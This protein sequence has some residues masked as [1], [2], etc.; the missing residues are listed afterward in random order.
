VIDTTFLRDVRYGLRLVA[1]APLPAGIAILTLGLGIGAA[2]AAFSVIDGVLLRP[3]PYPEPDRIVRLYQV[4]DSGARMNVSE[5]NFDD[6]TA[7]TRSFRAM[8]QVAPASAPVSLGDERVMLGGAVV[9][10][11]FFEVMGVQPV[12]GR[13][14]VEEEQRPGGRAAVVVSH[15]VWQDRLGA[16][17]L[18]DLSLRIGDEVHD[19]VG[20]MP[21]SF[22]YPSNWDYLTPR[23]RL[24]PQRSR[25][26]HNFQ[27]VARLADGVPLGLARAEISELSRRL[28]AHYG[29][30]TWMADAAAIPLHEQLTAAVKPALVLLFAA[31]ALLLVIACL[32]ASSLQLARAAT[33]GRELAVRMAIGADGWRIARQLVAETLVLSAMAGA[34]GVGLAVLGVRALVALQ[35]SNLPR[36]DD[37]AVHGGVLAFATGVAVV[38][39]ILL[40]LI[41]AVRSCRG[42]LADALRD[43]QRTSGGGSGERLRQVLVVSQVALTIVLLAGAALLAR[44]FARVVAV[45]PGFRTDHV[46]ILDLTWPYSP[47]PAVRERRVHTGRELLT[48]LRALPGM[49]DTGLVSAFPIGPGNFNNGQ[50]V[51][52]SRP[53]EIQTFEDFGRIAAQASQRTGFASYRIAS[54][55][56][57]TSMGIPLV[58]GRLFDEADDMDAPHVAL[59]SESLA[60]RQWPGQDPIGRVIQFGNMDGD[61]RGLRIVGIVGDVREVSTESLPGPIV[62]GHYQQ[63]PLS[64]FSVVVRGTATEAAGP[65]A[66]RIVRELDADLPLQVRTV[67][68]ALGRALEGRR[69]SLTLV[70]AF[71]GTALA[72]VALGVYGVVSFFVAQR[73]REIGIRLALGAEPADIRRL[74]VA[75]GA[76]LAGLGMTTGL[77][78]AVVLTRSLEGLLF[79]VDAL[80]T[81]AY[82]WVLGITSVAVLLAGYVPARRATRLAPLD[83]LRDGSS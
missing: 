82:G 23:E 56:Y 33:R 69:F 2:T 49:Q 19:V 79:G 62:Y 51:E 70:M 26:A 47:D 58:R 14:F 20:V 34:L 63:R 41:S 10:R 76:T 21:P 81:V 27:V 22:D 13:G 37:V 1:R 77:A 52:M 16:A 38:T 17:P 65:E 4:G 61:L 60:A 12:V 42:H 15:R 43:G 29:E 24:G 73:T 9:S 8:A 31:A 74:V 46:L 28:K 36:V 50:F 72:L 5:P 78:G 39:A 54:A 59:V 71:G 57:F 75:R 40:G 66:R 25:T 48:R 68:Q 45:D 30:D 64:R 6:W 80:D 18:P 11:G 53:D 67:E 7:G 83:A 55:G 3:L 32:N 35:P 44:S